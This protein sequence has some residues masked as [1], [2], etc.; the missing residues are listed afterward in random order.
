[1]ASTPYVPIMYHFIIDALC[2][3]PQVFSGAD[4]T[5]YCSAYLIISLVIS[6]VIS[7]YSI[8]GANRLDKEK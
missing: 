6:V 7:I 3:I 8:I 5:E 2:E 4:W 1:M